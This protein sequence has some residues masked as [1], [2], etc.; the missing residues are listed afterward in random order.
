MIGIGV[1]I[2]FGQTR[3]AVVVFEA[4][5]ALLLEDGASF[6]LLEDGTSKLLLE[7]T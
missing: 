3:F 6:F 2:L 7:P 1:G 4:G 5:D